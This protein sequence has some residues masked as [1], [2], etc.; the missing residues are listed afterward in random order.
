MNLIQPV[1]PGQRIS[2]VPTGILTSAKAPEIEFAEELQSHRDCKTQEP[3]EMAL[4][5]HE[6][7]SVDKSDE[8]ESDLPAEFAIAVPEVGQDDL[9]A[10]AMASGNDRH[11]ASPKDT[12]AAGIEVT[13]D[14]KTS[15]VSFASMAPGGAT[16]G[17]RSLEA[18]P[19]P[20][21][22]EGSIATTARIKEQW[23]PVAEREMSQGPRPQ[24][25]TASLSVDSDL[26]VR[27]LPSQP[28]LGSMDPAANLQSEPSLDEVVTGALATEG[29]A[30]THSAQF[31][32]IGGT[33]PVRKATQ[34]SLESPA[35]PETGRC[36][37]TAAKESQSLME[38]LVAEP[39][40][41]RTAV[42][43]ELLKQGREVSHPRPETDI[44]SFS[45]RTESD[46][47]LTAATHA[48]EPLSPSLRSAETAYAMARQLAD[49]LPRQPDR[50]VEILM[51]PEELGRVRMIMVGSDSQVTLQISAERPETGE[52]LRRHLDLL[53]QDLRGLGYT[54]VSFEFGN[55]RDGPPRQ[56]SQSE[57]EPAS[58]DTSDPASPEE[59][60]YVSQSGIDIRL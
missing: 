48:K 8:L 13:R 54:Q 21:V 31:A 16:R 52:L 10:L 33:T 39:E 60:Q 24:N 55:G 14:G 41:T 32:A 11:R 9:Q 38:R 35:A 15:S 1:T 49:S 56:P 59:Y 51:N 45:L 50:P 47:A 17:N 34:E 22:P 40:G 3:D 7:S 57:A 26:R 27:L 2:Q 44:S 5:E 12:L 46:L 29:R 43:I 20:S 25:T 58:S 53:A 23:L 6:V 18:V 37:T 28:A 4:Q 19:T 42:S 36:E 30:Q